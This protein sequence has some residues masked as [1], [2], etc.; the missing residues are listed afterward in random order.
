MLP[1]AQAY[2]APVEQVLHV[3]MWSQRG[4][5]RVPLPLLHAPL[6]FPSIPYT[7]LLKVTYEIPSSQ[8]QPLA[9]SLLGYVIQFAVEKLYRPLAH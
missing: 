3:F 4:S 7:V 8:R 6:T 9:L 1:T 2:N 5:F